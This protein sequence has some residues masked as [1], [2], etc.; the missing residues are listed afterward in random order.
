MEKIEDSSLK[1]L[2]LTEEDKANAAVNQVFRNEA[3]N[4]TAQYTRLAKRKFDVLQKVYENVEMLNDDLF[5][6]E[7]LEEMTKKEKL[8]A[9][10]IQLKALKSLSISFEEQ[11]QIVKQ[12][13][14]QI[15]NIIQKDK[16]VKDIPEESLN[17]IRD[18]VSKI[19]SNMENI[20]NE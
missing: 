18:A 10:S 4:L 9:L 13:N 3:T 1:P 6:P 8:F 16:N 15:N 7:S 12:I 2:E 20:N 17:K 11:Q 19:V 5:N 14:V